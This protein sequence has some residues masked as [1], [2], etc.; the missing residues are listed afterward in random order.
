MA[1]TYSPGLSVMQGISAA[2]QAHSGLLQN[3]AAMN[4][5]H[6][7]DRQE[8]VRSLLRD[9][10]YD[11]ALTKRETEAQSNKALRALGKVRDSLYNGSKDS[12]M[13]ALDMVSPLSNGQTRRLSS[14]GKSIE[15]VGLDGQ[16][17]GITPNYSGKMAERAML[18][19]YGMDIL[20]ERDI[21]FDR[22]ARDQMANLQMASMQNSALNKQNEMLMKALMGNLSGRGSGSGGGGKG[23]KGGAGGADGYW[24]AQTTDFSRVRGELMARIAMNEGLTMDEQ[25]N[26]DYSTM[27]P[28]EAAKVR[29]RV[30][31]RYLALENMY[32]QYRRAGLNPFEAIANADNAYARGEQQQQYNEQVAQSLAGQAQALAEIFK[33]ET[34]SVA[35][36]LSDA[37]NA[38]VDY[39][40]STPLGRKFTQLF[41]SSESPAANPSRY[42]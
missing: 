15:T 3:V 27:A 33:P 20:R 42:F 19:N 5:L 26:I 29:A 13:K 34:P 31:N 12:Y 9:I 25:G 28:E 38:A 17:L 35:G 16:V 10:A 32:S 36:T 40:A 11:Q 39:A 6:E 8:G 37:V 24:D 1:L 21:F 14:D 22:E 4:Q 30:R 23:G 7:W 41:N 2:N 18:Q